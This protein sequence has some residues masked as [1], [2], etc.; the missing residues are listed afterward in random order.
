MKRMLAWCS[1]HMLSAVTNGPFML[2]GYAN[3]HIVTGINS[4]TQRATTTQP[5]HTTPPLQ[6]QH[7]A[8]RPGMTQPQ[9]ITRGQEATADTGTGSHQA[10]AH[11]PI[12]HPDRKRQLRSQRETPHGPARTHRAPQKEATACSW[13]GYLT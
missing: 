8:N 5:R 1:E 2:P 10:S 13:R 3:D 4:V 12:V 7:F 6:L 9:H 11:N